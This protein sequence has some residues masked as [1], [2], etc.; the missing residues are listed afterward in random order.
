M[1]GLANDSTV[2]ENDQDL[3]QAFPCARKARIACSRKSVQRRK[4]IEY[5]R[6]QKALIHRRFV[7]RDGLR[8]SLVKQRELMVDV[9]EHDQ[10]RLGKESGINR[11]NQTCS[12]NASN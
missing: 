7:G 9:G 8:Y 5:K 1:N 4:E 2:L 11:Q 10:R 12:E 3:N 6:T